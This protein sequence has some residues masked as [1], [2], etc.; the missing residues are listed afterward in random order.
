MK[1]LYLPHSLTNG[2]IF[3]KM[4]K[5]KVVKCLAKISL[6]QIADELGI[7]RMTVSKVINNKPGVSDETRHSVAAKLVSSGYKKV[8]DY[9]LKTAMYT[10][11]IS[12]DE[13]DNI[14][15]VA[16]E[17]DF[18]DFWM[19]IINRISKE[20]TARGYNFV[21]DVLTREEAKDFVLP[22]NLQ[23]GKM[24]GII[25][26]NLYESK[27]IDELVAIDIPI[28][29]FDLTI[30]KSKQGI[31]SDVVLLE[32]KR[33][34]YT[35]TSHLIKKGYKRLGFIGDTSYS[36]TNLDRYTGF[37]RACEE[38]GIEVDPAFQITTSFKQHFYSDDEVMYY[39][40]RMERMPEA[41]VCA[42]DTIA[43]NLMECLFK[44]GYSVPND[45]AVTGYDGIR[46]SLFRQDILTTAIVD[47]SELGARLLKQLLYRMDNPSAA[48]ETIYIEPTIRFGQSTGD[49]QTFMKGGKQIV[50]DKTDSR[51]SEA[52]PR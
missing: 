1:L 8:S 36:K 13:K 23:K 33:T 10:D 26:I 38:N 3:I 30:E 49:I 14:A 51:G 48:R 17:P 19:N 37:C 16:T 11:A 50:S 35:L 44:Q 47:T 9:I 12:T 39:I 24:Q 34:V 15:V 43:I 45:I 40:S 2:E 29:F 21:Y 22:H 28:V 27:A 31:K 18:S 7:S 32:G 4:K 52:S 6:Q 5:H 20:V 42:N 41:F 25:V 46:G